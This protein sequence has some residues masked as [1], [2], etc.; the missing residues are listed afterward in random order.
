MPHGYVEG[1]FIGHLAVGIHL[2]LVM[3]GVWFFRI[4]LML[5]LRIHQAPV[6]FDPK[7]FTGPFLTF[8]GFAQYF[9]P[10]AF[11]QLYFYAQD[12]KSNTTKTITATIIMIVALAT[13]AG[14]FQPQW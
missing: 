13:L 4:S 10:L 1:D 9:V 11:A 12:S 3:A 14:I 5:W 6:S 2:F 7:T 8:L